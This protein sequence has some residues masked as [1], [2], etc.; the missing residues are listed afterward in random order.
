MISAF[1]RM[2]RRD[3]GVEHLRPLLPRYQLNKLIAPAADR[4]V[5]TQ[6][7][8]RDTAG[9]VLSDIAIRDRH[10]TAVNGLGRPRVSKCF[11]TTIGPTAQATPFSHRVNRLQPDPDT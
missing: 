9:C 8:G 5:H 10:D 11:R 4:A 7:G 3:A 2:T 6:A 1:L